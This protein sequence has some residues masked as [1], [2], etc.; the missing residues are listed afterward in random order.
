MKRIPSERSTVPVAVIAGRPVRLEPLIACGLLVACGLFGLGCR[1]SEPSTDATA[2][3]ETSP[4]Q[5][6]RNSTQDEKLAS[7]WGVD[8]EDVT[9]ASGV[10]SSYHNGEEADQ[11]LIVES[12]GGGVGVLD[13]DLDGR[14]D[15]FFP[16]GGEIEANQ[17]LR[18]LPATLWRSGD[19]M[20]FTDV[21]AAAGIDPRGPYSHGVA[22]ADFNQDGFPDIVVTGYGSVQLF[23]NC[24]DGTFV[25]RSAEWGLDTATWTSSAACGDF[26]QDGLVDLYLTCYVDWS[27]EKNPRCI[28]GSP[29]GQ[30]VCTPQQFAGLQ[31]QLYWNRGDGTFERA[32]ASAGLVPAGKGLGVIAVDVNQD[33]RLD[34]YVANDTTNN[35]LYLNQGDRKFK[36][37]GVISGAAF[38]HLGVPNGS[39]GLAVFDLEGELRTDLF[40]TNY[41]RETFAVY[42]NEGGGNFRCI[43]ERTGIAALG[44]LFVGF[45]TTAG[46]FNC[47]GREDLVVAN[48]HVMRY[49]ANDNLR[50][51]P[52][53]IANAGKGKLVRLKFDPPSYFSQRFASRGVVAADL[54][55]DGLLD[56]AFS[57]TNQPATVLRNR[58]KATSRSVTLR[59]I[60]TRSNRDA[61]GARVVLKTSA[62]DQL[63]QIHGGGSYLSQG[64][65]NLHWG[66]PAD[67]QP[68][69][70]EITWPDGSQQRIDELKL[71]QLQTIVQPLVTT[72]PT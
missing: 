15:L 24:G 28:G 60:G 25:E 39:M 42:R 32:D 14:L 56:L 51:D 46:D 58:S 52:L 41:E 49:P 66:L 68:L 22:V 37:V 67:V 55:G 65:Y 9:A 35:F 4:A 64:P 12:L 18:G 6:A 7:F 20:R 61:I 11:F 43:T 40:V 34:I 45:G 38:D 33:S 17:P 5:A 26:D 13:Y 69:S 10:N 71:G 2:S 63:R 36:E 27:W 48:G 29:S 70:A 62:G 44:S 53:Y 16:G 57:H 47:D 30:D 54:S 72:P 1:R 23:Q 8:F 50:Q 59:L 3:S 31:D 19:D 21:S